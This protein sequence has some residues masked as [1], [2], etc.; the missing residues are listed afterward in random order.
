ML[1]QIKF[2]QKMVPYRKTHL[3]SYGHSHSMTVPKNQFIDEDSQYRPYI[4]IDSSTIIYQR[5]N[6]RFKESVQ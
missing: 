4:S 2:N 3:H 5:I 6:S 1:K